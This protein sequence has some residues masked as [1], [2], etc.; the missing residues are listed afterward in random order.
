MLGDD[1]VK[2]I[3]KT[4]NKLSTFPDVIPALTKLR[5]KPNIT[6]VVFSNGSPDMLEQSIFGSSELAAMGRELFT[7]LVSTTS[8]Q[9]FKPAPETYWNLAE[10][11]NK[12]RSQM[13]DMWLLSGNPFDVVGALSVGMKVAWID[14]QGSGWNDSV[15]PEIRPTI[16]GRDLDQ[17]ISEIEKFVS[18]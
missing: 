10:R 16:I 9:K 3:M 15:K 13:G 1:T 4:Y 8:V 17:A 14:R 7:E 2:E 5:S 18:S 12:T 6:S 11:V